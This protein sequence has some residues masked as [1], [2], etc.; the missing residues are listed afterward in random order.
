M[1]RSIL[2]VVL[3]L[4]LVMSAAMAG[5]QSL[6]RKDV[7]QLQFMLTE[8]GYRP[9]GIDGVAGQGTLRA[10]QAFENDIVAPGAVPEQ[11]RID[12]TALFRVRFKYDRNHR[13]VSGP[14]PAPVRTVVRPSFDCARA[15]TPTELAIC[16]DANLAQLDS[17]MAAQYQSIRRR[18]SNAG[19][20]RLLE[21]QRGFLR[22]RDA[23][24]A[25]AGCIN[26]A[27]RFH[28]DRIAVMF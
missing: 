2:H 3:T 1:R 28:M 24:G 10:L 22:G 16:A 6:S 20:A 21:E 14:P 23:C 5:A 7:R 11:A 26:N 27:Y 18:L 25:N 19:R 17:Q 8:M 4:V 9:G 12:G 15:G 13:A